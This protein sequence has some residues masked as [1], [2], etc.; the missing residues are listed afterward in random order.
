MYTKYHHFLFKPG[1]PPKDIVALVKHREPNG[2][3]EH[4]TVSYYG[5]I[6]DPACRGKD[7]GHE[8]EDRVGKL[9]T[10]VGP[11]LVV[12]GDR[13]HECR[14]VWSFFKFFYTLKKYLKMGHSRPLF[15]SFR[16]F[17]TVYIKQMIY[18]KVCR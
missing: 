11:L 13:D 7:D 2:T 17:L 18:I 15:V 14:V 5:E 4:W 16:L 10:R 8:E 6:L 1:Q 3:R 9:L 12:A